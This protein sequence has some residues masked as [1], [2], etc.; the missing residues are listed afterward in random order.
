MS[1]HV[2]CVEVS[3]ATDLKLRTVRALTKEE[4]WIERGNMTEHPLGKRFVQP[5]VAVEQ[6]PFKRLM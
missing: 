6:R 2:L 5:A 1:F 4:G 3:G